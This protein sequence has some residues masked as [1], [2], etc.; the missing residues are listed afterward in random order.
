MK[1]N[2]KFGI[3]EISES[4][5]NILSFR[6]NNSIQSLK[7]TDGD[8]RVTRLTEEMAK[9]VEEVS[10]EPEHLRDK[11]EFLRRLQKLVQTV[12]PSALV[13]PF[14]SAVNG[15]WTPQSDIDIC[16]HVPSATTRQQQVPIGKRLRLLK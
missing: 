4:G 2:S 10:P 12:E 9:L 15:F 13:R 6:M 1:I 8:A 3:R 5:D 14:G 7:V 11:D 16:L